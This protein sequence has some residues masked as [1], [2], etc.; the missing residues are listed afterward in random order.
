METL[1]EL[2]RKRREHPAPPSAGS[3]AES[4]ALACFGK[5]FEDFSP[6]RIE[7]LLPDT[8]AEDIYFNDTLKAV[9]GRG[10]LAHYLAG[11]AGAVED[12]RV[13]VLSTTR[14]SEGE[15]LLRWRMSIRFKRLRRG[16]DTETVGL[17]HLRFGADGKVVYQQDYWNAAD[18]IY[19]HIPVLGSLI[20]LI[21]RRL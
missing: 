9:S 1:T 20:R 18:G 6:D 12:C 4:E 8:Y 15:H 2:E 21:K 14:T 3:A 10:A 13:Q 16:V 17:S 7:K 5:F 19:E 11:S